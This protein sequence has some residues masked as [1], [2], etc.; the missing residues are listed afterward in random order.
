[1]THQEKTN[2]VKKAILF[3]SNGVN[4]QHWSDYQIELLWRT[5]ETLYR[6]GGELTIR[7]ATAIEPRFKRRLERRKKLKETKDG[8]NKRID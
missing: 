2:Y 6:K 8:G 7:D 5:L 1:M 4:V 3:T